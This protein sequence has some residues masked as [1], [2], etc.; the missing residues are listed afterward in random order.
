[1]Q[2]T[3]RG[4][5]RGMPLIDGGRGTLG[6]RSVSSEREITAGRRVADEDTITLGL[7]DGVLIPYFGNLRAMQFDL[8]R[9]TSRAR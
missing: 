5:G 8:T 1:M 4:R 6:C 3:A 7:L 2:L 9:N